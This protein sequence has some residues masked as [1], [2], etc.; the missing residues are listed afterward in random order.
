MNIYTFAVYR[1]LKLTLGETEAGLEPDELNI[2]LNTTITVSSGLRVYN[3]DEDGNE[4][5]IVAENASQIQFDII[6]KAISIF[7]PALST[8]ALLASNVF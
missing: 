3:S 1:P 7:L 8:L 5:L 4:V 6:D 2:D